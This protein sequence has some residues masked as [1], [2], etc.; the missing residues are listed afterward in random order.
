MYPPKNLKARKVKIF[1]GLVLTLLASHIAVSQAAAQICVCVEEISTQLEISSVYPNPL[2]SEHE[3]VELTNTGP[4]I[5]DLAFYTIEDETHTP[6]LISGTVHAYSSTLVSDLTFQLNNGSDCVYLK[7]IDEN[8]IDSLCYSSSTKGIAVAKTASSSDNSDDSSDSSNSESSDESDTSESAAPT[9]P[10]LWP[11]FSEAVPN[12][13]GTDSTEEWIELYNPHSTNLNLT[14]LRL[15]DTDGGSSPYTLEGQMPPDSFLIISVE[16]SRISLNNS[17]DSI[18][19]LGVN[20]EVLWEVPYENPSEGQSYALIDGGYTW[21]STPT[22]NSANIYTNPEEASESESEFQDGDLSEEIEITEVYPNPEGPDQ[23]GEWIE[24]T[25][26]SDTA[27]NLGNWTIDDGEGGSDPYTF[28]DDT[29]I[30]PG[31]TL[32]IYRTETEIALNNSDE[33]VQLNDHTGETVDEI[34][35]EDSV[36]GESYA[37]IQ[38]EEIESTVASTSATIGNKVFSM[39]HWSQPSPGEENPHWLQFKGE[40]TAFDG[41]TMQL[42]D[43][44]STWD[45]QL[46][47]EDA[48]NTNALDNLIFQPGNIVQIQAFAKNDLFEIQSSELIQNKATENTTKIPWGMLG[49]ALLAAIWITYEILKHRKQKARISVAF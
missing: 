18:R 37:Q 46:P 29:V 49:S 15:D 33:M 48:S 43:G 39:W 3:W 40:I 27:V 26:N 2:D 16:D 22:P 34:E 45:L 10:N 4:D 6:M 23:D 7:D 30:E 25:N 13:E 5:L 8:E 19:L 42:F 47:E 31:E 35:Y 21:T 12:P 17:V 38:V 28:P 41:I 36:E 32:V 11:E 1:A 24:L 14:G 9:T 44:L 20:D